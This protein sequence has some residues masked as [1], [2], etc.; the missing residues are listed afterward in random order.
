MNDQQANQNATTQEPPRG[1]G[2]DLE[3]VVMPRRLTAENGAKALLIGEFHEVV[4]LECTACDEGDEGCEVCSGHGTFTYR[5][6]VSWATIKKIYDKAV[7][8]LGA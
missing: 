8:H 6:P 1:N 4:E 5:V 2:S 3:A 7:Q